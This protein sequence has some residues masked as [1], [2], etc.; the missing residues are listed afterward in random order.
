MHGAGRMLQPELLLMPSFRCNA[1]WLVTHFRGLADLSPSGGMSF[2][3][4]AQ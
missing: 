1:V 3:A 2:G 4:L